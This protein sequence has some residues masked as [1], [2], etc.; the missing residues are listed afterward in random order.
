MKEQEPRN[1]RIDLELKKTDFH[2][3]QFVPESLLPKCPVGAPFK[4]VVRVDE[5]SCSEDWR[6]DVCRWLVRNGC[7]YAMTWGNT[8]SDWHDGIDDASIRANGDD[9]G[10]DERP[11]LTTWHD[12]DTLAEVM[13][14]AKYAARHSV[15]ELKDTLFLH[16]GGTNQQ[17]EMTKLW[18]DAD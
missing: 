7:L 13:W 8:C 14:F 1:F 6:R 4:A 17:Y 11:V 18:L 15:I 9:I 5:E 16:V 3:L 12:T 2:Y 10:R